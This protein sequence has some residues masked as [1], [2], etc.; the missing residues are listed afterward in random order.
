MNVTTE[1]WGNIIGFPPTLSYY[2]MRN[3]YLS[4][5][6]IEE[7]E[8]ALYVF[9]DTTNIIPETLRDLDVIIAKKLNVVEINHYNDT[10]MI[11]TVII[12]ET[13]REDYK[14]FLEGKY[15]KMS[16]EFAA[17]YKAGDLP[18]ECILKTEARRKKLQN[19]LDSCGVTEP[20]TDEMELL[21]VLKESREHLKLIKREEGSLH[22]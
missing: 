2:G 17:Q 16:K 10:T 8:N 21:S 18:Y 20:L 15:S 9:F 13:F 12:P 6:S 11:L 5:E 4:I 19:Y 14:L 3:I 1:F 7:R 22:I